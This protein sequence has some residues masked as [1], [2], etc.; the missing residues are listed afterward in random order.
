MSLADGMNGDFEMLDESPIL[1]V[2]E[3]KKIGNQ[4]LKKKLVKGD[5]GW[6]TP[7][8]GGEIEVHYTGTLL[9][10]TQFDSNRYRGTPFKFTLGQGQVIKGWDQGIK[11]MKK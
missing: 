3:E 6:E 8:N 7:E 1:K 4:G 9:N 10:G 11:T 2:G 5:E